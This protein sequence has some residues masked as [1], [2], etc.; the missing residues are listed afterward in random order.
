MKLRPWL[1][2]VLKVMARDGVAWGE[3]EAVGNIEQWT[4]EQ[5]REWAEGLAKVVDDGLATVQFDFRNYSLGNH[6]YI[7][8]RRVTPAGQAV[9]D[10]RRTREAAEAELD[11]S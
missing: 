8:K 4:G 2:Q 5:I 7:V 11:P 10:A 1:V 9:I 6:D 3:E